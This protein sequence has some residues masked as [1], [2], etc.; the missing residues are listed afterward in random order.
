MQKLLFLPRFLGASLI[1]GAACSTNATS[2]DAGLDASVT[3]ESGSIDAA[4]I[5]AAVLPVD[6][7]PPSTDFCSL[8]GSWVET[9]QGLE[10]IPDPANPWNDLSWLTIPVGFCAHYFGTV[11]TTRQLR[12]A[13]GGDLFVASPYTF[14]TGG[15]NNGISGIA[16]LPDDNHDGYADKTI[17]YLSHLP[18]TQGLMFTGGFLYYQDHADILRVPFQPHDRAPSGVSQ[19]VTTIPLY[20]DGLHWPKVMDIAQDGTIYVTNGSTDGQKCIPG[21]PPAG[22]ILQLE[23]DG[24]T[25]VVA[26]G[27]RNPIAL[28][29]ETNHDVCLAAELARDYSGPN[30]GR[31]KLLPVRQDDDWGFPCCATQ[32]T[33]YSD[34]TYPDGAVP[35]CS[36]VVSESAA[37]I[38]GETPFGIDFE[39]GLWPAPWGGRVFVTLHGEVELWEGARLVAIALDPSSGLPITSSDLDGGFD[40]QNAL[41]FA[42][43]WADGHRDHGRPAPIAFAP[44]GRLFLGDDQRGAILWIAPIGLAKP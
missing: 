11:A 28:R 14:T 20:Q 34:T 29:C 16:I 10:V 12:F 1:A 44:D 27:F 17:T 18:S 15:A 36:G 25:T 35:D 38:I 31:E 23:A 5:D 8:P 33:R 43:G 9:P 40:M 21:S 32:N 39:P 6:A 3:Q 24:G 30:G 26:R 4:V 19:L 2:P 37:F 7:R 13:P 42:A 41:D 22:A